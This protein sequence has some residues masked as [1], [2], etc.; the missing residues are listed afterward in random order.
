MGDHTGAEET[1]LASAPTRQ[2]PP[3]PTRPPPVAPS[4]V[5]QVEITGVERRSK[6]TKHYAY[7]IRLH[8]SNGKHTTAVRS[9]N[10]F[11]DFHCGLL[12][13]FPL[14]AGEQDKPRTL[15]VLPGK[16][17][18]SKTEEKAAKFVQSV[19]SYCV[20]LLSMP[21]NVSRDADVL[22]FF[23]PTRADF[24]FEDLERTLGVQPS[25]SRGTEVGRTATW[26]AASSS[27][28]SSS[29]NGRNQPHMG[30]DRDAQR[31]SSIDAAIEAA[32]SIADATAT[33]DC[34][35][36]DE[37]DPSRANLLLVKNRL[38]YC[39]GEV[40]Q[41]VRMTDCPGGHWWCRNREGVEGHVPS[42]D[43]AVDL[44]AVEEQTRR[45]TT[46]TEQ[47]QRQKQRRPHLHSTESQT[48]LTTV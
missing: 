41:V 13:K 28:S 35:S 19:E 7:V 33:A 26:P 42:S 14:E 6:P 39:K 17:A 25:V 9:H 45:L 29:P 18:Q 46:G 24:A 47:Q 40:L 3:A 37:V 27:S 34:I 15:P 1:P 22:Q 2:P 10:E 4:Y 43:L 11:F 8:W 36:G 21:P 16:S 48:K 38:P 5:R 44:A 31:R 20:S 12:T 23:Q 32:S 30:H